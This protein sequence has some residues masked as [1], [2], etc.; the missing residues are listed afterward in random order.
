MP[1]DFEDY[2]REKNFK[3]CPMS[4][5][6]AIRNEI[7]YELSVEEVLDHVNKVH[8]VMAKAMQADHHYGVI[9]GTGTAEKPG[10]PTLLKPGAEL[11]CVMFR[12][13]PRF[14]PDR[15]TEIREENGHL[16]V[17]CTCQLW[18]SPTNTLQGEGM[19]SCSTREKKYAWRQANR[20]CPEC[21]AE[22]V[23]KSKKEFGWYC[24][25]KKGGCGEQFHGD[26]PRIIS[27]PEGRVPNEDLAE[28]Y[29]TV[30]K[31]ASKR[32][33]IAAVLNVTAASDIFTQDLED[34]APEPVKEMPKEQPKPVA[35]KEPTEQ[36]KPVAQKEPTEQPKSNL[37]RLTKDNIGQYITAAG[38]HYEANGWGTRE[39]LE[40]HIDR[41]CQ[42]LGYPGSFA[43][44]SQQQ[45]SHIVEEMKVYRARKEYEK[46]EREK[47]SRQEIEPLTPVEA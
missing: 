28:Y 22:A 33:L 47:Q 27:Q 38:V 17:T 18:H 30:L 42:G 40:E 19:A 44:W 46:E 3:R 8:K 45:V 43:E 23:F 6:L 21:G 36:P 16:T 13:G 2:K 24:W 41:L 1:E 34:F 14:P 10:K 4:N 26:D 7:K 37:K 5:E 31:M 32:A 11:M 35:Q 9:P 29:N 25:A 12:L 20:R 39:E 15:Q